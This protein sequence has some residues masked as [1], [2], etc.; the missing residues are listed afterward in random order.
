MKICI[1]IPVYNEGKTIGQIVK[2]LK[3]NK[4]DVIVI[5]D[6]STDGSGQKAAA[7]GAKVFTNETK[8]GKG[9]SL[10][11]G[12]EYLLAQGYEGVIMMDGDAQH[13]VGD[14][15]HFFS[16]IN[17]HPISVVTGNR[18]VDAK[19]M[20]RVRL[21]TNKVMSWLIS[22]VCGQTIPDTQCGYRYIHSKIL[23]ELKL[24]SGDFE[25]ESEILI[26]SSRKGYKIYSVPI[27]T[28]YQGEVSHIR[29]F[30]DT[31]RFIRYLL[32]EIFSKS[33]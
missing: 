10:K 2:A 17:D 3:A 8:L 23:K 27:K 26:K 13:D 7:E 20:P 4:L 18:M 15:D 9:D 1:L 11:K 31:L 19:D 24:I 29:P 21:M 30:K 32:R 28:I 6:G 16:V 22:S 25:I 14:L 12:F 33:D 5:D